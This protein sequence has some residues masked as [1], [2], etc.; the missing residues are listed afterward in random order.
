M[1]VPSLLPFDWFIGLCALHMTVTFMAVSFIYLR[2]FFPENVKPHFQE[3][4]VR[5]FGTTRN[6]LKRSQYVSIGL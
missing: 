2:L 1:D 3:G 4:L 6:A 5:V